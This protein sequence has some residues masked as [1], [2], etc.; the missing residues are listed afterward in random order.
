[1]NSF[2]MPE[3]ISHERRRFLSTA[4]MAFTAAQ[5][6]MLTSVKAE[7]ASKTALEKSTVRPGANTSFSSMKQIDAGLLNVGYA[8]AGPSDGPAVILLHGW[9]YTVLSTLLRCWLRQATG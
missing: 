1:M 4:A 5:F 6:G 9:P 7:A 3:D 8:E 2:K